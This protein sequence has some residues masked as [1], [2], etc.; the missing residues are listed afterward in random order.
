MLTSITLENFKSFR[1]ATVPLGP[2]TLLV[3]TNASGKSN[4]R[5]ALRFV[6]GIGRGYSLTEIIGEKWGE[7]GELQWKGIRGGTSEAVFGD[8]EEFSIETEIRLRVRFRPGVSSQAYRHRI[9]VA[10]ER[11]KL[12][13]RVTA[14]SLYAGSLMYFDSNPV[15]DPPKQQDEEHLLVRL[16]RGGAH[17]RSNPVLMLLSSSPAIVQLPRKLRMATK[18]RRSMG[19]TVMQWNMG[20]LLRSMTS[21]RFLDLSPEATRLP[22]LPGRQVLGDRGENLSSVLQMICED[23]SRKSSLLE[24]IKALTPLDVVDFDFP[25]DFSGRV[26]VHLVE[27]SGRKISAHSASDGTLRFLAML[28]ALLGA[29]GARFYFFEE[30]ENGIHPTRLHLLVQLIEQQCRTG[31]V[32]VVATTHSPQLLGFLNPASRQDALLMY[33]LKDAD[34][35]RVRRIIEL[36]R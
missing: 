8:G 18:A 30:L 14:E 32:Q 2:F 35:S 24:W 12:G 27:K 33:R 28:A 1:K 9:T 19:E 31:R 3:G 6:H 23:S 13:P 10:I 16:P 4:L 21:M 11:E 15:D 34:D 5:D 25:K 29:D 20:D 22:S 17:R 26:L 7:G 36:P